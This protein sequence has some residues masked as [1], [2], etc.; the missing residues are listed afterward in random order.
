MYCRVR[1][2][3]ERE[4]EINSTPVVTILDRYTLRIKVKK[5]GSTGPS[6]GDGYKEENFTFDCC[7]DG[8][9]Q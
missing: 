6:G 2:M 7:F 4:S 5:E 1:P 3:S 8:N 9:S